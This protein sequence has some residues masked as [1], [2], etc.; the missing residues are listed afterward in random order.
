MSDENPHGLPPEVFKELQEKYK[1]TLP[2][3]LKAIRDAIEALEKAPRAETL[4]AL[5]F[6]VHKMAGNAGTYGYQ[7]VTDLCRAGDA[8]LG[9]ILT[10]FDSS[11]LTPALYSELKALLKQIQGAFGLNG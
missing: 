3:R 8:R 11:K 4:T 2:E 9:K 7:K 6:L 10:P 1:A 5:R